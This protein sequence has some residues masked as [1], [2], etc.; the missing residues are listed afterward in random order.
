MSEAYQ[1]GGTYDVPLSIID[2]PDPP[3]RDDTISDELQEL[4]HDIANR[5]LDNAI[6]LRPVEGGRLEIIFGHRRYIAHCM[7]G[8]DTIRATVRHVTKSDA[9]IMKIQENLMRVQTNAMEEAL[10]VERLLTT[11]HMSIERV[12]ASLQRTPQYVRTLTKLLKLSDLG[13][14]KLRQGKISKA[15]ALEIIQGRTEAAQNVLLSYAMDG[16]SALALKMWRE[17]A[18]L[19]NEDV[20]LDDAVQAARAKQVEGV[21]V[22]G[23]LC[24]WCAQFTPY[25]QVQYTQACAA[26]HNLHVE[27]H[28]RFNAPSP[29]GGGDNRQ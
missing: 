20:S 18:E 4:A 29:E 26:C 1:D 24:N 27:F 21:G 2:E 14:Q 5:G 8:K 9:E 15:Q 7:L 13:R 12:A 10:A 6:A 25:G 28:E 11:L 16:T 3:M 23:V 17:K 19:T 22:Q